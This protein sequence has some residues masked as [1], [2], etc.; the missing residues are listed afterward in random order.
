MW[1]DFR[2]VHKYAYTRYI[3]VSKSDFEMF[4]YYLLAIV[5]LEM[6]LRMWKYRIGQ[7]ILIISDILSGK[8][9]WRNDTCLSSMSNRLI[10]L[11]MSNICVLF[12]LEFCLHKTKFK[13]VR[14][15]PLSHGRYFG[16]RGAYMVNYWSHIFCCIC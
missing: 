8:S 16:K 15:Q 11:L 2:V 13:F 12:L 6:T 14:S 4:K 9:K 7:N 1:E 5:D 3:I 10:S